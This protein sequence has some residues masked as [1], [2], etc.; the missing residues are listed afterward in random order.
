[1]YPLLRALVLLII[2]HSALRAQT[3]TLVAAGATWKYLDTGTAP[4]AAWITA[5]YNDTPWAAGPAEL[6]YGDADEATTISF[7]ADPLAKRITTYFRHAFTAGIPGSYTTLRCILKRD[8]GAV[9]YLNGSE[10]RR[11]NLPATGTIASTTTALATVEGAAQLDTFFLSP[12]LLSATGANL[13]AVEV[14]QISG[15]STDVS[16]SLI[17]E[18]IS[19]PATVTRGPY[20]QRGSG[21][22]MSVRWRTD[23]PCGS[24]I[25]GGTVPGSYPIVVTD[26]AAVLEH[27]LRFTALTPNTRYFYRI[28]TPDSVLAGDSTH[29]FTTAPPDTSTRPIRVAVFGDCGRNDNGFQTGSLGAYQQHLAGKG[30]QAADLLLLLGD[31]AYPNGT[32]SDYN[33]KFFPAYSSNIL[34]NHPLFPSPGNHEYA[35]NSARQADHAVAYYD[36]FS[37]PTAG[38]SGGVASGSESY[39][40]F[41]WGPVHFI[42]MD[43]YGQEDA[44]TTRLYDTSGA[45]VTWLKA[46]LAANTRKWT[47]A[48]WHH[49]PYCMGNHNSDTETELVLIRQRLLKILERAGVDMVLCGHSHAYERSLLTRGHTGTEASYSKALHAADSSSARYDGT[50]NSCPYVTPSGKVTHGTVYVVSGSSGADGPVQAGFPHDALPFGVDDGG[51]LYFEVSDNRLDA[52]FLRRDSVV[53]DQFTIVKDARR[54]DTFFATAGVPL[55]LTASWPGGPYGWPGGQTTRSITITPAVGGPDTVVTIVRDAAAGP[56]VCLADTF[57]ALVVYPLALSPLSLSGVWREGRVPVLRWTTGSAQE[58]ARPTAFTLSRSTDGST[59]STIAA[60]TGAAADLA[61]EDVS[62]APLADSPVLYYRIAAAGGRPGNTV[63]LQRSRTPGGLEI[64]PVPA[65][66]VLHIRFD[67]APAGSVSLRVTDAAGRTLLT[68][69]LPSRRVV[70]LPL[71]DLPTGAVLVLQ[72]E[73]GGVRVVRRFVR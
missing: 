43:S 33:T 54:R 23:I 67:D 50:A 64:Y 40:S 30:L 28:G 29:F 14:H 9:V 3:T 34:R 41:D 68:T 6:G 26:T 51:M 66:D 49:P 16:F 59:F 8:D 10:V 22:A 57:V 21:T 55:T 63:R 19:T 38:E 37:V 46:D 7:G 27:E 18:G 42:S 72:V 65:A 36:L 32:E 1:M 58:D 70:D 48:Y 5:L 69:A 31:N 73:A 2:F 53:A 4:P 15:T 35:D 45:Q 25:S 39:Y 11:S 20:L 12:T 61:W 13:L 47:V 44:G 62:A 52:R 56:G 24:R 17:L 71:G 60:P